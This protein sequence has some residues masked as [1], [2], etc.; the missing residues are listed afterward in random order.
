HGV[1]GAG[2]SA[3]RGAGPRPQA[4]RRAPGP[5]ARSPRSVPGPGRAVRGH[6]RAGPLHGARK[7]GQRGARGRLRGPAVA[8]GAAGRDPGRGRT[9]ARGADRGKDDAVNLTA[10]LNAGS[11]TLNNALKEMRIL[12]D[13]TRAEWNDPVGRSFEEHQWLP[14]EA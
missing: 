14:L 1:P 4:G 7:R 12:W 11:A 13:A 2:P 10:S 3:V 9:P 8:R 5:E 6:A